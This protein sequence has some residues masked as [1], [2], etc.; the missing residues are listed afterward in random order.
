MDLFKTVWP[1]LPDLNGVQLGLARVED[2]GFIGL[3][4]RHFVESGLSGWSWNPNRVAEQIQNP[5]SLVMVARDEEIVVATAIVEYGRTVSHLNLLVVE[6][7]YQR[8]GI[9]TCLVRYIE[10]SAVLLGHDKIHLEVRLH[11]FGARA[12]Y[13]TLG[14]KEIEVQKNYY[15]GRE[16]AVYMVHEIQT[17]PTTQFSEK[18]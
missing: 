16:A 18:Q 1:D 11:N 2:I 7:G 9:G 3:L 6:P 14:Y 8:T 17:S 5:D 4:S 13:R 12:F 15:R 10:N